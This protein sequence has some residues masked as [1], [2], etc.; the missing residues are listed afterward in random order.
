MRFE[1]GMG[2]RTD[3]EEERE[4]GEGTRGCGEWEAGVAVPEV[5]EAERERA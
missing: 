2:R 1:W 3:G 4:E 5:P